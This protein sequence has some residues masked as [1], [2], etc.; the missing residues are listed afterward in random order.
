M[1]EYIMSGTS[2]TRILTKTWAENPTLIE[3]GKDVLMEINQYKDTHKLGLLYNALTEKNGVEW[4]GHYSDSVS[5][6]HTDSGGLQIMQQGKTITPE[7]AENIFK[8]QVQA[9]H[10]AMSF[11]SIP[12]K[13]VAEGNART[14]M[15]IK[16]FD[17]S[18]NIACG[19][20]SGKYVQQQIEC[21]KA[22]RDTSL[23][24]T[25]PLIII[26][27]NSKQDFIDYF[28]AIKSQITPENYK[29]VGGFAI[30]GSAIGVGVLEALDSCYAF[31]CLDIPEEMGTQLHFLGYGSMSRLLPIIMLF[32]NGMLSKYTISY[33]STSHSSRYFFGSTF[34]EGMKLVD[35]GRE[36]HNSK[37]TY[38]FG[39]IYDR[40]EH[41]IVQHLKV[42]RDEWLHNVTGNLVDSTKF[43]VTETQNQNFVDCCYAS[44]LLAALFSIQNFIHLMDECIHDTE[45]NHVSKKVKGYKII[46]YLE[47]NCNTG[48]L[49]Y[50]VHRSKVSK[51][52]KSN[53]IERITDNDAEV[54][55]TLDSFF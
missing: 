51:Y 3:F 11:D 13:I 24:H 20:A 8:V 25:K 4:L 38:I 26:Q 6:I 46:Q 12:I 14:D 41:N 5:S 35:F 39:K 28:E 19:I 49:W 45:Y 1:L 47:E 18:K 2:Y 29:E 42:T 10:I 31:D 55:I 36:A 23:F 54:F 43:H 53:R 17:V 22:N 33:D 37:A 15:S 48:D 9:S 40:F 16:R 30:A 7:I 52:L 21:F 27:G 44:V 50:D 34:D 32:R